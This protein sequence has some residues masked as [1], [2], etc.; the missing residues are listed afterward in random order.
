MTRHTSI[1]T[2]WNW[3]LSCG[4]VILV[5][6]VLLWLKISLANIALLLPLLRSVVWSVHSLC[7]GVCWNQ[8]MG[9]RYPFFYC[10][11]RCVLDICGSAWTLESFSW[12]MGRADGVQDWDDHHTSCLL[13]S[14]GLPCLFSLPKRRIVLFPDP[15]VFIVPIRFCIPTLIFTFAKTFRI[16]LLL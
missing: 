12:N 9:I 16:A 1:V 10:H 13:R 14:V 2:S 5:L 11:C 4:P 8:S 7:S 6:F 15:I 3:I